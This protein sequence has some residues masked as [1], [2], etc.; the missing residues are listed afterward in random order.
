MFGMELKKIEAIKGS[1]DNDYEKN[2]MK[3]TFNSCH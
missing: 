2:F 1:K 3:I